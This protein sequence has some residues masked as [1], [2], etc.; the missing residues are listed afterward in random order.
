MIEGLSEFNGCLKKWR[1][2]KVYGFWPKKSATRWKTHYKDKVE[3]ERVWKIKCG[4]GEWFH[5]NGTSINHVDVWNVCQT[6]WGAWGAWGSCSSSCDGGKITRTR[7]CFYKGDC[8][9]TDRDTGRGHLRIML[10]LGYLRAYS[11][12]CPFM[13]YNFLYLL[14][15]IQV[16][17]I[18]YLR[19]RFEFY[20]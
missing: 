10:T 20:I 11:A 6:Q 1:N 9:I 15:W 4:V 2:S 12:I 19:I 8:A 14:I 3:E 18:G 7:E 17:L 5:Q 13:E 16:Q